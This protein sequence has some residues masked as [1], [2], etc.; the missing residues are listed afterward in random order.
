MRRRLVTTNPRDMRYSKEHEWVKMQPDGTALVGITAFAQDQL[1]DA[2]YVSLPKAGSSVKQFAKLGEVESVKAVSDIFSP[3]GGEI[4][5]VNAELAAHPEL[6]NKEPYGKAWLIK[7]R[8]TSASELEKLLSA[9][10]Y[11]AFLS[12]GD[13]RKGH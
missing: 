10:Q 3:L 8:P 7:L 1:G 12:S 4:L 5:E 9:E 2:V 11:E 6:L 13:A